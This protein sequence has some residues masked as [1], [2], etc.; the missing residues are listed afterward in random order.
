LNIDATD[1]VV[2][3]V[4]YVQVAGGVDRDTPRSVEDG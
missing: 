4:G 1:R 2:V 3:A